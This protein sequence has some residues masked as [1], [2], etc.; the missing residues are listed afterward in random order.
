M[1]DGP[2]SRQFGTDSQRDGAYT[3]RTCRSECAIAGQV[4]ERHVPSE[5]ER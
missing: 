4:S 3:G 1:I 5:S 2:T